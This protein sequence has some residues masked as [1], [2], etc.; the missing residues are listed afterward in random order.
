MVLIESQG[1]RAVVEDNQSKDSFVHKLTLD[2]SK[3]VPKDKKKKGAKDPAFDKVL[4]LLARIR[5]RNPQIDL[6]IIDTNYN[7]GRFLVDDG[8]GILT[9]MGCI[10][11]KA[12][13]YLKR[14]DI[15]VIGYY[16][17]N[18]KKPFIKGISPFARKK[19]TIPEP[20]DSPP[21]TPIFVAGL[22]I[23]HKGFWWSPHHSR[24]PIPLFSLGPKP[25]ETLVDEPMVKFVENL[26]LGPENEGTVVLFN[27]RV[28][29]TEP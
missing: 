13:K 9:E 16:D 11:A 17:D 21:P 24:D 15:V 2:I 26:G 10:D 7:N 23:Q 12:R 28:D 8:F 18:P 25:I 4:S 3:F 1:L 22:W 5:I 6:G 27:S 14:G 29:L 20:T 19:F